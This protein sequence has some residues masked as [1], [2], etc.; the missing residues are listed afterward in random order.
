MPVELTLS[1]EASLPMTVAAGLFAAVIV[2]W[3]RRRNWSRGRIS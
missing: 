2:Y 1:S 3:T